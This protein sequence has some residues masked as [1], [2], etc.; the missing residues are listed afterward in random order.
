M[1][2]LNHLFVFF[3]S[4]FLFRTATA[5]PQFVA[6]EILL[7]DLA[8][9]YDWNE[10]LGTPPAPAPG[11][12]VCA[13]VPYTYRES[14]EK[15][16]ARIS[17]VFCFRFFGPNVHTLFDLPYSKDL[18]RFKDPA[19]RELLPYSWVQEWDRGN[20]AE[21]DVYY[22]LVRRVESC[23]IDGLPFPPTAEECWEYMKGN[24][25]NCN[26]MGRGGMLT[27]GCLQFVLLLRF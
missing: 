24:W 21:D 14:H 2:L 13:E 10:T 27:I 5:S 9:R 26:N 17:R 11:R 23:R 7:E 4:I 22:F 6:D 18:F 1:G 19:F 25:K 15:R 8:R 20:N 3:A 16:M 12:R